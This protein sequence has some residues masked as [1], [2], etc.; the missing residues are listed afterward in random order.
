MKASWGSCKKDCLGPQFQTGCNLQSSGRHVYKDHYQTFVGSNICWI[1]HLLDL[2]QEG[3]D[4]V[5]SQDD[6]TKVL[7][8]LRKRDSSHGPAGAIEASQSQGLQPQHQN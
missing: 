7:P 3:L 5:S 1:E 4:R 2:S 6:W 8:F